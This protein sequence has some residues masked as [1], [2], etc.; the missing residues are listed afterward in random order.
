MD[1]NGHDIGELRDKEFTPSDIRENTFKRARS[2]NK[3]IIILII[4]LFIVTNV[5]SCLL[6]F[7][8]IT[9]ASLKEITDYRKIGLVKG[10]I[11]RFYNGEY[12]EDSLI[13]NAIEGMVNSLGDPY[14]VY[15]DEDEY[16]EFN[17]S[18]KGQYVGIGVEVAPDNGKVVILSII[19]NSPAKRSGLMEGDYIIEVSG[20]DTREGNIDEVKSLLMGDEGTSV[21]LTVERDGMNISY[22]IERDSIYTPSV[23]Y[24]EVSDDILYIKLNI[25]DDE[26]YEGIKGALSSSSAKG[27]ILDLRGNPGGMV[28]PCIDIAS[29]FI[30]EGNVIYSSEDK[31]G[32]V[33][34][35]KSKG[36]DAQDREIVV[37]GDSYSASASEI[38][39]GALK[40]NDRA[41]FV[42]TKT[43][44]K[45]VAQMVFDL[46][47]VSG[48]KVTSS[49]N[50]TP[51]GECINK[52]GIEP[53]VYV[54][55]PQSEVIKNKKSSHGDKELL[56]KNDPQY[57][58]ALEVL[59]EGMHK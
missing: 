2:K 41:V 1:I 7:R 59:L 30:P 46:G 22:T 21:S 35:I 53:D 44:G 19:D 4:S 28:Q 33:E 39:I 48:V 5:L 3:I 52:V 24:R 23:E 54:D 17:L 13:D 37:L 15:M 42:G 12:E 27:I 32:G 58:K 20:H 14:T 57:N 16:N 31:S 51:N 55:Y 45:G 47:G 34:V 29:E 10:I 25:F 26:S 11:S 43:F 40:D 49:K 36:G 9:G 8:F 18:I 50:Y 38:L 56:L 6:S